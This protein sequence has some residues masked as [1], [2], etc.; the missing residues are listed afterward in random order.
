MAW[1]HSSGDKFD[2]EKFIAYAAHFAQI[3]NPR[4]VFITIAQ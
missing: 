1:A 3:N 4:V 2:T